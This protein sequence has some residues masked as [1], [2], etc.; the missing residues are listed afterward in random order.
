MSP[1]R[2]CTAPP[3]ATQHK[4][5]H[6]KTVHLA[7]QRA[8]SPFGR[9]GGGAPHTFRN[10]IV[11][12]SRLFDNRHLG[13]QCTEHRYTYFR[14]TL[15]RILAYYFGFVLLFSSLSDAH[16]RT[17]ACVGFSL[18]MTTL[19]ERERRRS[20]ASLPLIPLS[21]LFCDPFAANADICQASCPVSGAKLGCK[22]YTSPVQFYLD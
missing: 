8:L 6:A 21:C 22:A 16:L 9:R 20:L 19:D 5:A 3:T 13:A 10:S 7:Q 17:R 4:N 15:G 11:Q 1:P 12:Q 2:R 18:E 14:C